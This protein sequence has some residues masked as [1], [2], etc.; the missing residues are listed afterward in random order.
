ML[1]WIT[2]GIV[3]I[4]KVKGAYTD[5]L[6]FDVI[7]EWGRMIPDPDRWPSSK[8]GKGF[9]EVAKKVHDMGLKFGIHVMRGISTQAVNANIPILDITKG[10]AYEE[11]GRLWH[12][13]DIGL[14]DRACAQMPHGFMSVNT[15]LGSGRAFLRSIH[16]QYAD[17]GVDFVKHDCVIGDDLDLEEISLVSEGLQ[18]ENA[19]RGLNRSILYSLSPG[20]SVTPTMAKDVKDLVNMYR[21]T[22]DDWDLWQD[23]AAHFIVTRDFSTAN[24]IGAPGLLGKSWPDLDL[25]TLG[26]LTNPGPH[27]SYNLKSRGA[28]NSDDS[29]VHGQVSSHVWRGEEDMTYMQQY[30]G[31]LHLLAT[32][33]MEFCLE[34]SPKWKLTS[35]EFMRANADSGGV[36]SWIVTGREGEIYL[37]FFNLNSEKTEI[38]AKK[39]DLAKALPGTKK[40]PVVSCESG[41]LEFS[42]GVTFHRYLSDKATSA[43][44]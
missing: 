41:G 32:D 19:L 29:V 6:G 20:T 25:I 31:K 33:A 35:K 7:D 26:W 15:K 42:G 2:Y 13:K 40:L 1:S 28:K 12:A 24:M 27:R 16:Q 30:Q 43:F 9:T 14:K 4:R 34:A 11:A 22:G 10:C 17:W 18:S 44:Q 37:A 8:G 39:S 36:C 5:S 38:S 3:G 23:V 21:I